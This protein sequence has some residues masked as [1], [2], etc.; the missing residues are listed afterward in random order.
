MVKIVEVFDH[1]M[2]DSKGNIY[3]TVIVLLA[4][5]FAWSEK[6]TFLTA[7]I[8]RRRRDADKSLHRKVH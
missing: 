6:Y 7:G 5:L 2:I 8:R 4:L 1:F 3:Y